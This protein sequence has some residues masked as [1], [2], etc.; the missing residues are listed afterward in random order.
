MTG[1]PLDECRR[2]FRL[3]AGH[4]VTGAFD[5]PV[6]EKDFFQRFLEHKMDFDL[7]EYRF[8]GGH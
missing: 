3:S 2:I 6:E 8:W 7:Y 5:I 4:P 1:I